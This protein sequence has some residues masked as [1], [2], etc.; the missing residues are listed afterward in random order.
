MNNLSC[1][2]GSNQRQTVVHNDGVQWIE[3][4]FR[5]D[6]TKIGL[7]LVTQQLLVKIIRGI[8]LLLDHIKDYILSQ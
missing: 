3:T 8:F 7:V 6:G 4:F 1:T 2:S 5:M